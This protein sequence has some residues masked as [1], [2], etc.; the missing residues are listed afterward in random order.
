VPPN[1]IPSHK[2]TTPTRIRLGMETRVLRL[3]P[4][5]EVSAHAAAAVFPGLAPAGRPARHQGDRD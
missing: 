5:G 2:P 4:G 1:E 3:A